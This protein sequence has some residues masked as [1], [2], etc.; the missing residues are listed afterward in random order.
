MEESSPTEFSCMDVRLY[1]QEV[2]HTPKIALK[3]PPW[4]FLGDIYVGVSK[5]KGTPKWMVYNDFRMENPIKMDDLGVPLFLETSMWPHT[6][7]LSSFVGALGPFN[8]QGTNISHQ[9]YVGISSSQ[10]AFHTHL[11]L[12]SWIV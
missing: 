2:S 12:V 9:G 3:G 11:L 5:H 4:N 6:A 7:N 1:V 8:P 10:K